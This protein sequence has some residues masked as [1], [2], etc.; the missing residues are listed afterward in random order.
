MA[1][2]RLLLFDVGQISGGCS[3]RMG[4]WGM[5]VILLWTEGDHRPRGRCCPASSV[6]VVMA[7]GL[8]HDAERIEP[9]RGEVRRRVLRPLLGRV[10]DG[11]ARSHDMSVH[12]VHRTAGRHHE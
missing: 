9:E 10:H 5:S 8:E 11:A 6:A 7:H 2:T 12:V 1:R 4:Y 3:A